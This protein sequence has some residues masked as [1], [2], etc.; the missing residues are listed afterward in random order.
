MNC[1]RAYLSHFYSK[2]RIT[3]PMGYLMGSVIVSQALG[4]P[5]AAGLMA[6]DGRGGLRGWQWMFLVEGALAVIV[7]VS[8]FFLPRDIDAI[9]CLT[10][11]EKEALHE[12]MLGHEKPV[13][14]A[15]Q[16]LLG[17]VR[18]PVVWVAGCGIKFFRDI[19]F[20]GLMY[21]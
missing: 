1:C 20:Y 19:G 12:S 14:S 21:W 2:A 10:D 9:R 15:K 5:L 8:F 7:A 16:A 17:A 18:S 4:A 13:A 3:L 11:L 6:L